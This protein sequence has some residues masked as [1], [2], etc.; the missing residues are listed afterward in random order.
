MKNLL[1]TVL[2]RRWVSLGLLPA[3]MLMWMG[4]SVYAQT[5][6]ETLFDVYRLSSEAS[7]E[8]DND[9]MVAF[10]VVQEEDKDASVLANRVNATMSW[11]VN[12]L[13]PNTTIDTRTRDYQT[14]PKYENSSARRLIA[15]QAQQ[16]IEL[17]T[18][19]FSAAGKAIQALQEKMTVQSIQLS[20]KP[21]SREKASDALI[22]EALDSFKRR[23]RLVQQN[24]SSSGYRVLDIDIRTQ[25][26]GSGAIST[27]MMSM[28]QESDSV[29]TAPAIAAGTTTVFVNVEGRIQ[30]D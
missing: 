1:I 9:L 29:E 7:V 15:W 8:V 10:L 28:A 14:Y 17:K 30:L 2:C 19:D 11:A 18:S 25:Q 22:R 5:A 6:S 26:G 4:Q 27:R 3:L 12:V 23:A 13:R 24:M 20:V 21:D 16:V